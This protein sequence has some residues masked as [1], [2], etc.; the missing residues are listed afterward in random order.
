M[1]TDNNRELTDAELSNDVLALVNGE[2]T[3]DEL[4]SVNGGSSPTILQYAAG[5]V[6]TGVA[7][8]VVLPI[9]RATT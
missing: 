7:E 4:D 2:L 1:T 5:M 9:I 6:I 8:G 3:D